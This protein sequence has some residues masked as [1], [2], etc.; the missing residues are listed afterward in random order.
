MILLA[1]EFSSPV[2]SVAVVSV[3]EGPGRLQAGAPTDNPDLTRPQNGSVLSSVSDGGAKG[4][5]PLKLVESAL[6]QAG[7]KREA[8]AAIAVGLGPGSYVGIRAAIAIAQGWE[9]GRGVRV[10]GIGSGDC[11]V[12]GARRRGCL[13]KVNVAIDAQ[14]GEI[15]SAEYELDREGFRQLQPLRLLTIAES[16]SNFGANVIGPEVNRWFEGGRVIVPEA[17]ELG[18]LAVDRAA[19]VKAEELEPIYLRATSFVKAPPPR[20]LPEAGGRR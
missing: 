10:T 12:A 7:K 11:I 18:R 16:Q 8:I 13:G 9:L 19:W 3:P 4:I 2:R 17:Q 6:L 20:I 1:L 14:R 15:Y 5:R